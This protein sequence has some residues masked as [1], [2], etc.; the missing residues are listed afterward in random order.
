MQTVLVVFK[1]AHQYPAL[2]ILSIEQPN[3][4]RTN[5][6]ALLHYS[7]PGND[8]LFWKYMY[9]YSI[10]LSQHDYKRY[11]LYVH[12]REKRPTL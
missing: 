1:M 9:N 5:N 11:K 2:I 4:S 8:R 3:D 10:K 6:T 12:R 7:N